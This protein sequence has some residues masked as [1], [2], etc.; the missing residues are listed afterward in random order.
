MTDS[1][2]DRIRATLSDGRRAAEE[3]ADLSFDACNA[4]GLRFATAAA[5][6]AFEENLMEANQHA[7]LD[8]LVAN[9]VAADPSLKRTPAE[10]KVKA[11][12]PY[13]GYR[14]RKAE[15]AA[16]AEEAR[17]LSKF[18]F[19]RARVLAGGAS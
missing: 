7:Y 4:E 8:E 1:T 13:I 5:A 17:A 19:N 14:E 16:T 10:A 18:F 6:A 15:Y 11:A 9:E 12:E 2:F 3:S